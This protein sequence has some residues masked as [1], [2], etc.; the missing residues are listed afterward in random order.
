VGSDEE[1]GGKGSESENFS[2]FLGFIITTTSAI[3]ATINTTTIVT[4]QP[5]RARKAAAAAILC[6]IQAT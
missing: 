3:E 6:Y 4:I 2:H 5:S 1:G